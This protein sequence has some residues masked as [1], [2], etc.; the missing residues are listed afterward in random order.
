[1]WTAKELTRS[2][3][4]EVISAV[5]SIVSHSQ[6]KNGNGPEGKP[7]EL[8]GSIEASIGPEPTL[9]SPLP[10]KIKRDHEDGRIAHL[11]ER[12]LR[13]HVTGL[14]FSG[15][16]IRSGTF[17]VGF[18][19]GLAAM[20]LIR[21]FDYLSTVSGGGYAGAWLTAWLKR[22][23]GDPANVEKMLNSSRIHQ[24]K[25]NRQLLERGEVVDEEPEAL[26][27]LRAHS[28]YLFPRHGILSPDTWTVILIWFRN[29]IINLTML[30]PAIMLL[31]VSSRIV[32]AIYRNFNPLDFE[33]PVGFFSLLG[34]ALVVVLVCLAIAFLYN[35]MP[36]LA[37]ILAVGAGIV[38][39]IYRNFN[40]LVFEKSACFFFWELA[41]G[42]GLAIALFYSK[43]LL[44]YLT[45]PSVRHPRI[46]G[47]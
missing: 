21:R 20:G 25:A 14:A 1:L 8:A 17:A 10:E 16:G 23:G 9:G 6:A 5:R 33:M 37:I 13:N 15:G 41:L 30:L 45:R 22:E 4:D 42:G 19:Q 2:D 35:K 28:R 11:R 36:L 38:L 43:M 3:K 39:A 47:S 31:V 34:L 26:R 24:A 7:A 27:H 44:L 12:A 32:L 18:L 29:V 40:P 46:A